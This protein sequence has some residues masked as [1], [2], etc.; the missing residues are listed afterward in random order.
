MLGQPGDAESPQAVPLPDL[1]CDFPCGQQPHLCRESW[2]HTSLFRLAAL[3]SY[4]G[5]QLLL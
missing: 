5:S 4:N 3:L 2:G 1:Q